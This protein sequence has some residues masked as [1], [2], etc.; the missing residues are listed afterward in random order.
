MSI[1][2]LFSYPYLIGTIPIIILL[3]LITSYII[4]LLLGLICYLRSMCHFKRKDKNYTGKH[5]LIFGGSSGVGQ[6]LAFRLARQGVYLSIASRSEAKLKTTQEQCQSINSNTKCDY[7]ICDVTKVDDV[8]NT[9]KQSINKNGF[10]SLIVNSAGIAHPGFIE[11]IDYSQYERDMNL[12][13]FG[14][15][16]VIKETKMLYDIEDK[17]ENVDIVCIGS[18]LGLIGSIGYSAYAPTKFAMK[19]LLDSLRFEFLGTKINLH[20]FAPS[21][22]DTPGL[23]IENQN[24]PKLVSDMENNAQTVTG[25]YAA[26]TLL[27]NMDKYV[28]TTEADLELLKT[29]T[30]FMSGHSLLDLLVAPLAAI[31]ICFIR[32]GIEGNIMKNIRQK[33]D[34]LLY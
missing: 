4:I 24:K 29:A 32:K 13:Y 3:S 21:N 20:Y 22:M 1:S 18:A 16:R 23:A 33:K 30:H 15:L 2:F 10:P 9:L 17:K 5:I 34:S 12:N 11:E 8:K 6:A 19:G 7:Y 28:I 25:D 26:H 14:A 27:C 31:A